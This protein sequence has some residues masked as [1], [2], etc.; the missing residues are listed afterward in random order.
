VEVDEVDGVEVELL[1]VVDELVEGW[2]V[3][4]AV[5]ALDD[6][7]SSVVSGKVS[8]SSVSASTSAELSVVVAVDWTVGLSWAGAGAAPAGLIT[9][10]KT[11]ANTIAAI[12]KTIP[13]IAAITNG[14]FVC[15]NNANFAPNPGWGAFILSLIIWI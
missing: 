10:K 11:I 12:N 2:D 13:A 5:L 4:E 8:P 1:V 15:H 14:L 9:V 7:E 6:E 3:V